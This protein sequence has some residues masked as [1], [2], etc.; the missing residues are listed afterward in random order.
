[1]MIFNER[2]HKHQPWS[3]YMG[4]SCQAMSGQSITDSYVARVLAGDSPLQTAMGV[5]FKIVTFF[6]TYVLAVDICN[7]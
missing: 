5:A 3:S 4:I 6:P 2:P 7:I 1:M